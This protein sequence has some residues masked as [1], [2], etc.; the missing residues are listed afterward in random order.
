MGLLG[1]VTAAWWCSGTPCRG[2]KGLG[3]RDAI[4]RAG[5]GRATVSGR[6]VEAEQRKAGRRR[7]QSG[8]DVFGRTGGVLDVGS[9]LA[10][11][12]EGRRT[13]QRRHILPPKARLSLGC[14]VS[15]WVQTGRQAAEQSP[16][17]GRELAACGPMAM[18]GGRWA[19]SYLP[20]PWAMA[21]ATATATALWSARRVPCIVATATKA[22]PVPFP[23]ASVSIHVR[24]NA[25]AMDRRSVP[26]F[27]L[28]YR[29][30][31][32]AMASRGQR[33]FAWLRCV[34]PFAAVRSLVGLT[35]LS[36]CLPRPTRAQ[37]RTAAPAPS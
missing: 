5:V 35:Q 1:S 28:R 13:A 25:A 34:L 19:I 7:L 11:R 10:G 33:C 37:G 36:I 21:T 3:Q 2:S 4:C 24:R 26:A 22:L 14:V 31:G 8:L 12:E 27:R 15:G 30:N 6:G 32:D 29:A 17:R 18:M 16:N 23:R 9:C 20:R